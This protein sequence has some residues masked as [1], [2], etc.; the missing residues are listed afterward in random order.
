ML[1]GRSQP[2]ESIAIGFANW[3]LHAHIWTFRQ[4]LPC[5]FVREK[6]QDEIHVGMFLGSSWMRT[7]LYQLS[8]GS[9]CLSRGNLV[10]LIPLRPPNPTRELLQSGSSSRHVHHAQSFGYTALQ[11]RNPASGDSRRRLISYLLPS[12]ETTSSGIRQCHHEVQLTASGMRSMPIK[13]FTRKP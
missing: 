2:V 4:G 6:N 13:D 8:F 7:T 9:C 5:M 1:G 11:S 12:V 3:A 10:R